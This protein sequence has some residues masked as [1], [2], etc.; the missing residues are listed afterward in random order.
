MKRF[1]RRGGP[2]QTLAF[3]QARLAFSLPGLVFSLVAL[4]GAACGYSLAG[5]GAFLPPHIKTIGIPT[6]ENRSDRVEVEKLLTD[7]VVE[8]L[9]SRG[10]YIVRPEA[11]GVDAVLSGTVVAFTVAPVAFGEAGAQ[12]QGVN[13]A[14]RYSVVV[15][16]RVDFKDLVQNK[17]LWSDSNFSFRDEYE[18]GENPEEFFDQ[19]S[20]SLQ[21][22]AQE[23]A[24]SLVSR[25]LEA[26]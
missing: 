6:F 17:T 7:K 14:S 26:F 21:R 19:E 15:R 22:L 16:A 25:I 4:A 11:T 9:T 1:L 13:Q 5:R 20:L 8:E 10:K 2:A 18:I 12:P 3:W 24:K 23:F